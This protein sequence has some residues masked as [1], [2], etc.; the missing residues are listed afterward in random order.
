[1][2]L[3]DFVSEF[4][5]NE[6]FWFCQSD[7]TDK[8]LTE[9]YGHLLDACHESE[10]SFR[11]VVL[12]DQL[13]RHVF[14]HTQSAHVI[15]YFLELALENYVNADLGNL[16]DVEWCFAHLPLRHTFDP[17]WIIRVIHDAWE[18]VK[19][20]CHEFLSRF[21]KASYERCPTDDQSAFITKTFDDVVFS[22]E[23]HRDTLAFV[24]TGP[25]AKIDPK[26]HIVKAVKKALDAHR[27]KKLIMSL[28]GGSDSM[29]AFHV[30]DGL[31]K[32][33][34]YE[35]DVVMIN[36]T[37]RE[38]AYDEESYV[39][40][41]ANSLGYGINV[42]RIEEIKRKRCVEHDMRTLYE[43][44]TRNVRYSTYKTVS[45]DSMVVMGHN[46][47][48]CLENIL[49]NVSNCHKYDNLS[50]MDVVT[51]QDNVVF[52]RPMLDVPKDDIMS[53]ARDHNIPYL[54]N[55]TPPYFQR[56]KIR[57]SVV[58]CLNS[59]N[60]MFIPGLFKTKDM[61]SNMHRVVEINVNTLIKT[62]DNFEAT[63][64][65]SYIEMG[66]YFWALFL[67]KM[68]PGDV[69]RNR[70]IHCLM[71]SFSRFSDYSKFELNKRIRLVMKMT[72]N[73]IYMQFDTK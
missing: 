45:K 1:M 5:S 35:M 4:L 38:S 36:Y 49:Q 62:F 47:D 58:P 64:D 68:F 51:E 56:G 25:V 23:K 34:K 21:L 66:E 70:M 16:T 59:W 50:G 73:G 48:D 60:D 65:R 6:S 29:V 13:P 33:Y 15:R 61:I 17:E 72:S 14:R 44:Y 12:Y 30:L 7:A 39:V 42:R 41:W 32:E 54:P 31:K 10:D 9:K 22:P 55:S 19:P 2:S 69:F 40:D 20:D 67:K 46:K 63:V 18:R 26:N 43:S 28:S 27:P 53:Y 24:P 71:E 11:L 37:N 57:N 52:F 3:N 8:Y